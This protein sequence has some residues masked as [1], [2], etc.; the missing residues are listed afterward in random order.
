MHVHRFLSREFSLSG[1]LCLMGVKTEELLYLLL[2]TGEV[3]T[4]PT[5]RNL[6]GSF[7]EWLYRNGLLRQLQRLEKQRFVERLRDPRGDRLVRL[8]EV[9]RHRAL[10]GRDPEIC[11]ERR[12]D[13]RWRLGI[14]DV[15]VAR[16]STRNRIRRSLRSR[17]FGYLQ[18][19]VWITPDPIDD[20]TTLLTGGNVDVESLIMMEARPCAGES[21]AQIVAGAW[22]FV[23]INEQYAKYQLVLSRRPKSRIDSIVA[24]RRFSRWLREEHESWTDAL[25]WDPLLPEPLLPRDYAG[26]RAWRNRL[27]VM[28]DAGEQ[29]RAFRFKP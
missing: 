22:D 10:G 13:G 17:G 7:E 8:T 20:V 1:R 3:L 16:N 2:W 26:R 9:G 11:W 6:T 21:N 4:R 28:A 23:Q 25:S 12:W 18:D 29:M 14:F 27:R 15:P 5:F 19:S 24:A